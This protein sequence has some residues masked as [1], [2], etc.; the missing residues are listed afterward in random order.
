[1]T[2]QAVPFG[3]HLYN[4]CF[5]LLLFA[6]GMDFL[7]TRLATPNLLLEANPIA[8]RLGWRGGMIVNFFFCVGFAFWP[9]PAVII[10]TTSVLVAA[11][12]FQLAWLMRTMGEHNYRDWFSE[13]LQETPPSLF[14]FCLVA[15]TVLTGFVGGALL[16]FT[17]L[18]Q[19]VTFGIGTG[20]IGY[21]AAVLVF[22]GLSLWRQRRAARMR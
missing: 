8:R 11:R 18:D 15:Q 2:D 14:I 9:L 20:V 7:S 10:S 21:A 16:L 3:S 5:V 12:N 6:R 1:M 22:T 13:R 19:W 4:V 17:P